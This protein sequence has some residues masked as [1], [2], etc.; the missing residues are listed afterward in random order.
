MIRLSK[1]EKTNKL[2]WFGIPVIRPYMKPY[3]SSVLV[4]ISFGAISSLIDTIFPLFNRYALDY[5]IGDGILDTIPFFLL[6]YVLLLAVQVVL[7]YISTYLCSKVELGI[8][9]DLKNET[10]RHLQ[11]L[12]LSYF[13]TNSVGYIHARVMSDTDRIGVLCSWRLMDAAWNLSYII[14]VFAVML[15][16][17][18]S[19]A[20]LLLALVPVAAILSLFF[21]RKLVRLNRSVREINSQITGNFNEGITGARSIR[22]L[23]VEDVVGREFMDKTK[24]MKKTATRS[25][26]Y[27]ALFSAT[28]TFLSSAALALVLWRG[29][30]PA[31]QTMMKVGTLSVFMSYALGMI[32]PIQNLIRMLIDIIAIQVNIERFQTLLH[33]RSDVNDTSPVIEKYGDFFSPKKENWEDIKGEICFEDVSFQYP[34][35]DELVVDHFSRSIRAGTNVAIVGDTGAGKSTLVNLVCRFYEPTRGRVLIDGRDVRERSQLWL[36]SHIGYVLQTPHLFSGTIRDNMRFGKEDATDEEIWAALRIVSADRI[37]KKT[38]LGLDYEVGEGGDLLSTGEKQLISFA[39]AIIADPAILVLDEATSSIDT[40]TEKMIQDAIKNV[41]KGRT[42]FVIAHRLSTITEADL[43]LVV[44]DGKIIESGTHKELIS[45]GGY[46]SKLYMRQYE[47]MQTK[48]VFSEET[49]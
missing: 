42:S 8:G 26:H 24:E 20:L 22:S 4:M 17:R 2:A 32:E 35:G 1:T 25:G 11:T 19:L 36:H 18:P 47:D 48:S 28:V 43:I 39:R 6:F 49:G 41:T 33:T 7:N 13:N 40:V 44:R 12:S 45:A 21:Q 29:S 14:C 9:R 16:I 10:F 34:D 15:M 37:V 27:A 30:S 46:Y 23:V 5:Y 31:G 3:I 38:E